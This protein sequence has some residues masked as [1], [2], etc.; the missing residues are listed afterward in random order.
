MI[1]LGL[2][3]L[4]SVTALLYSLLLIFVEFAPLEIMALLFAWHL[5][6][7]LFYYYS[8]NWAKIFRSSALLFLPPLFVAS[9]NRAAWAFFVI[10]V[11]LLL[12]YLEK[13]LQKGG[14]DDYVDS[15][16][17]VLLIYAVA[18]FIRWGL[19]DIGGML[20]RRHLSSSCISCLQ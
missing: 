18:F 8:H 17:R 20:T 1:S 9:G 3:E 15:F 13:F 4:L 16:K 6:V 10:T 14:Y 5:A 7:G 12:L 19:A 11:P 2:L